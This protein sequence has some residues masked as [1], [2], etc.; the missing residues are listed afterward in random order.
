MEPVWLVSKGNVLASADLATTRAERR[1]GL[2]GAAAVTTPLVLTP[3][4]W[5]HSVGMRTT[6]DVA[7]VGADGAVLDIRTLRPFRVAPPN[8]RAVTVIEA[9]RGSFERWGLAV[10]DQVEVRRP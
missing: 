5:V 1:R 7:Y 4:N 3:C 8:R 10:G 6:V 9:A 2:I